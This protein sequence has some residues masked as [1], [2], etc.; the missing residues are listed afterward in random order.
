MRIAAT[1]AELASRAR[2][3]WWNLARRDRGEQ[4]LNA[5]LESYVDLLA[6]EHERGGASPDAARRRARK[7][8]TQTE[9]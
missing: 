2:S 3:L 6:A 4:A 1:I 5:E 7:E 8:V 9:R